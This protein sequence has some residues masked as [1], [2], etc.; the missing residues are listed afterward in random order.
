[1]ISEIRPNCAHK[2][3]QVFF[4]WQLEKKKCSK[5]VFHERTTAE[6]HRNMKIAR[7]NRAIKLSCSD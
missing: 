5:Q 3:T 7:D 2:N 6:I 1:M 4:T